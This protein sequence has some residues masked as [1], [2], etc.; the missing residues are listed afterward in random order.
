[1]KD[2]FFAG[3][4]T[5]LP[6]LLFVIILGWVLGVLFYWIDCIQLLFPNSVIDKLNLPD[7]VIK[8]IGLVIICFSILCIGVVSRQP[9][10]SRKFKAWLEPVIYRIPLL[11][12][13]FR[14]TNQVT[15]TLKDTDS[16]K[17]VVLVQF[18]TERSWS[19]GF[20][21][22]ENP[23]V[24]C[25]AMNKPDLVSV[26][27]PTTPNPTSGFLMFMSP[28]DFVETNV[29]VSSAITLIISMGAAGATNEIIEESHSVW[30]VGFFNKRLFSW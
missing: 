4:R 16:F 18:P 27:V 28:N 5:I 23:K 29:P 24:L 8:T 10:M 15:S 19:V 2:N 21:T 9:R 14:I 7:I 13:L 6:F 11:G 17:K 26:F 25:D 22:G 3:L 30:R 12:N 1:M 20:V